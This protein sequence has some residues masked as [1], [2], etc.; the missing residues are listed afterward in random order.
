MKK[1]FIIMLMACSGATYAQQDSTVNKKDSTSTSS[2][3][4]IRV[5]GIVIVKKPGTNSRTI[6]INPSSTPK[7]LKNVSTN[8]WMIDI[9][10]SGLRDLTDYASN[11]ARDFM[12]NA[13]STPINKGDF[14]LRNTRISNFN[15]WI[16]MRKHNIAAHVLN[17][18]YGVGI[19]S[20]NY[21]YKT[22]I[23]Y[24]D[25]A[26][27]YV[28]RENISFAKNKLVASYLT[29]PL[30]LNINTSPNSK[31]KGLQLSAGVSGGVLYRAR[32]K[33]ESQERG[34][35]KVKTDFNLERFKFALV[36]ELG[37]GPLKF[38]GSYALTPLH[39]FGLD[40]MP[41]N[42]GIRLGNL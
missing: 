31:K 42:V 4:T 38:Y 32:Q 35:Q 26:T 29:V 20:N 2:A 34:K 11:E 30:M 23:T 33:Q 27:P 37:V 16:F 18:K 41:Y 28:K 21:Y 22:P 6:N 39:Q 7:K 19:E 14:A 36:G 5:G 13:G 17:L 15:L 40:Q 8:W 10:Y 25:G 3:D 9:G 12:Q 1:L 24:V